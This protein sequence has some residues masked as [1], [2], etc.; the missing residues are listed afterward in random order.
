[1]ADKAVARLKDFNRRTLDAV[2]AKIMYFYSLA[3]ENLGELP[4]IRR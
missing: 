2:S 3:Y 1:M 4:S